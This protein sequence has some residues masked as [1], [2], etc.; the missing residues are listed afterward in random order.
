[1]EVPEQDTREISEFTCI[2][3]VR[4]AVRVLRDNGILSPGVDVDKLEKE[5]VSLGQAND[6]SVAVG[7]PYQFYVPEYCDA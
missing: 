5:L 4:E 1:M 6:L 7:Q 2:V 3:W